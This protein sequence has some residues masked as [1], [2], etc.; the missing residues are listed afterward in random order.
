M[1]GRIEKIYLTGLMVLSS[2]VST[3]T[4]RCIS[5]I[6]EEVK[7]VGKNEDKCSSCILYTVLFSIFFTISIGVGVYFVYCKYMNH[8]KEN[9]SKYDYTY[10]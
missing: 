7:V 8:N 1:F 2:L 10:Y 6:I 9:V 5:I 3:T 4:L